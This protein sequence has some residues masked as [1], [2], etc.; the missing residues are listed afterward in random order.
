MSHTQALTAPPSSPQQR[1]NFAAYGSSRREELNYQS[2]DLDLSLS[3]NRGRSVSLSISSEQLSY[4]G[5]YD[6]FGVTAG[7]GPQALSPHGKAPQ[8]IAELVRKFAGDAAA[9]QFQALSNKHGSE[10]G[11]SVQHEELSLEYE[12]LSI[13]IEG[14]ASLL[15]D[16]F[17]APETALRI[18]DFAKSLGAMAG[19][20]P[21][22]EGFD[23]F[24]SEISRG[25][26][27]GFEAVESILGKLPEISQNTHS[28]LHEMLD[29]LAIDPKA[30]LHKLAYPEPEKPE[31][32]EEIQN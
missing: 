15:K 9:E 25:I 17:S 23:H 14:D 32:V 1:D 2:F 29:A 12:S 20:Q 24:L 8:G 7:K 3:D 5:T 28:L 11:F 18:M 27:E 16:Y 13:E 22:G 21:G 26:E 4:M 10:Q 19:V 6:K 31:K 30:D